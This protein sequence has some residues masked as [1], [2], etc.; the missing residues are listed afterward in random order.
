[1]MKPMIKPL[2]NKRGGVLVFF[3][4]TL[5]V[6]MGMAGLAVDVAH[7]YGVKS[8]LQGAADAAALAGA[9]ALTGSTPVASAT[10]AA[11]T[12][13]AANYA[14]VYPPGVA[15]AG[16]AIPVTLN[17]GDVT[18]GNWDGATF[19]ANGAPLNAVRVV[20]NRL[21]GSGQPMAV[22]WLI[23]VMSLVSGSDYSTTGVSAV[24]IAAITSNNALPIAVNEYWG[25][26]KQYPQSYMRSIDVDGS[27][28]LAG[29]ALP[30]CIF[31]ILGSDANDDMTPSDQASFVYLGWRNPYYDGTGQWYSAENG[32]G[33]CTSNCPMPTTTPNGN[34]MD[35]LKA[36]YYPY[37]FTGIPDTLVP[38]VAVREP[39]NNTKPS[40]KYY[41]T[42]ANYY[43]KP[44]SNCPYA[45]IAYFAS[46]GNVPKLP[47]GPGG[48][49]FCDAYPKGSKILVMV[50]DGTVTGNVPQAVTIVGYGIIQI[51]GYT[52]SP[53]N[54]KSLSSLG[55]SGSTAYG[56]AVNIKTLYPAL[57]TDASV[58]LSDPY[59]IQPAA[60]GDPC[61][62]LTWLKTNIQVPQVNLVDSG[63][64]MHYGMTTH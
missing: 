46:S 11:T 48:E 63:N 47:K 16:T 39:Y 17:S 52:N 36:S 55:A 37:L 4:I 54:G 56:H 28:G 53:W 12:V 31:G 60:G 8:Q 19:T 61:A 10:S 41:T 9:N 49:R 64:D 57:P 18:T 45:T 35:N 50:Y 62:F 30:G 34:N 1:M 7:L 29:T 13:A 14:D 59:I 22:N 23:R 3:A 2:S 33:D 21:G 32:T 25:G 24:A 51:D 27:A 6:M 42:Q 5:I 40:N 43:P 20:A 44:T 58:D 38:P 15:N 26:S